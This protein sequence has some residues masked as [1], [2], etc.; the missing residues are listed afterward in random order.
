M[1][2]QKDS[3]WSCVN[4]VLANNVLWPKH[5]KTVEIYWKISYTENDKTATNNATTAKTGDSNNTL[6]LVTMILSF[7]AMA[8]VTR[9]SRI[10]KNQK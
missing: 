8:S 7:V 9:R 5:V 10:L 2:G 3:V 4:N 1:A 6:V